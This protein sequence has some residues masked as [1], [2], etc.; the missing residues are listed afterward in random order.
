MRRRRRFRI[1]YNAKKMVFVRVMCIFIILLGIFMGIDHKIRPTINALAQNQAVILATRL[2]DEAVSTYVAEKHIDYT[3]LIHLEKDSKNNVTSIEANAMR[4]NSMKSEI[5]MSITDQLGAIENKKL[6]IPLGTLIGTEW[7]NGRGPRI[8]FYIT[9]SGNVKTGL[10]SQFYNAG[11]NQTLH[12]ISLEITT[13]IYIICPGY[14]TSTQVAT[15]V[16]V[17]ETVI[18]GEVPETYYYLNTDPDEYA[19]NY[20][21][22]RD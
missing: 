21:V 20:P 11:I 19:S 8:T 1:R 16:P 12:S 22:H 2:I 18:V 9:L 5:S 15:N 13:D 17:A 6:Q 3:T 4:I 10:V 14:D 7:L